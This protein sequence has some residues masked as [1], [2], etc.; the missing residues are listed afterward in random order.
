MHLINF[1]ANATYL[2]IQLIVINKHI[3]RTMDYALNISIGEAIRKVLSEKK[4]SQSKLAQ[5]LKTSTTYVARLLKKETIDTKTLCEISKELHYNFF[6]DFVPELDKGNS[7]EDKQNRDSHQQEYFCIHP[8]NIGNEIMATMKNKRVTQAELGDYLGVS[9][10]EIS[11]LL[12]SDCIDTGKL[13]RISN[14]LKTPFFAFFYNW[15]LEDDFLLANKAD[16]I[17]NKY[18]DQ[19]KFSFSSEPYVTDMFTDSAIDKYRSTITTLCEIL[20]KLEKENNKLSNKL[21]ELTN[22]K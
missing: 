5:S 14:Y 20:V 15:Y 10:Q 22:S 1:N 9:H 6:A 2:Y 8:I 16:V 13:I 4:I 11:R 21:K 12:K 18:I 7:E 17:L 19:Y 3:Q